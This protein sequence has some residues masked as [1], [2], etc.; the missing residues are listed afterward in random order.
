ML[1][2]LTSVKRPSLK[3]GQSSRVRLLYDGRER[4]LN[5][6]QLVGDDAAEDAAPALAQVRVVHLGTALAVG[7]H[8]PQLVALRAPQ[9]IDERDAK[10]VQVYQGHAL[11]DRD[12]LDGVGVGEEVGVNLV[13]LAEA[14]ARQGR[15]QYRL[16]ARCARLVHVARDV[17]GVGR[18]G[19][20]LALRPLAGHVVVAELNQNVV[21]FE[22][23]GLLPPAFGGVGL[24]AAAVLR[25]VDDFRIGRDEA[26]EARPPAVGLA[27]GR[28]ADEH[29]LYLARGGQRLAI[30]GLAV[31]AHVLDNEPRDIAD[32][33]RLG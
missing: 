1:F 12:A 14:A 33:A 20:C 15:Y 27:H 3:A 25:H 8:L 26:L 16:R 4:G 6:A 22:R 5:L 23:K 2:S 11:L 17:R 10:G 32:D 7:L 28:V 9:R 31:D 19:V 29:Y 18:V 24:R 13:V 21:A 30:D